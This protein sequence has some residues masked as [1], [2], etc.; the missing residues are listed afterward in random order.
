[1]PTPPGDDN[2]GPPAPHPRRE[3]LTPVDPSLHTH[4]DSLEAEALGMSVLGSL[5]CF[6]SDPSPSSAWVSET[7]GH[8]LRQYSCVAES[9]LPEE[10]K[11][12]A[13]TAVSILVDVGTCLSPP[14]W[15]HQTSHGPPH[16]PK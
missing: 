10:E 11:P 2:A 16:H 12:R 14:D 1:M 8:L 15:T 9:P 5:P 7:L 13:M 4:W 3:G 6:P